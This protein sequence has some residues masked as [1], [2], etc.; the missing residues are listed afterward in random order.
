MNPERN[1]ADPDFEP[2]DAQLQELTRSAFAHVQAA[3]D[4]S[5]NRLRLEI[6]Q[7]RMLALQRISGVLSEAS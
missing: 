6:A 3:H 1:L 2:T 7:A 4:A 5:L